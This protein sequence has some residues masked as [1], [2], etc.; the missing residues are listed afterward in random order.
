[1][2]LA[3]SSSYLTSSAERALASD[4]LTLGRVAASHGFQPISS[5]LCVGPGLVIFRERLAGQ[6]EMQPQRFDNLLVM[7]LDKGQ[8]EE[9]R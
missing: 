3:A 7:V 1:V 2:P 6:T 8:M 4:R 5:T 9:Q